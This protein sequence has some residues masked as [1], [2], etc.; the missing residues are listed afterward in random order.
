MPKMATSEARDN[1]TELINRAAYSGERTVI[2][3]R[4]KGMAA[5]VPMEDFDLLEKVEDLI[6]RD[7]LK[8]ARVEVRKKGTIP[9]EKVKADAGR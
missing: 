5:I 4:G 9:W 7:L 8:K 3:R 1:F 2:R 6:D